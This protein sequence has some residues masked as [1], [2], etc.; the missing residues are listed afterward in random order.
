MAVYPGVQGT[1]SRGPSY[2]ARVIRVLGTVE[3]KMKYA[4][5]LGGYLWSLTKPLAYFAVLLLVFRHLLTSSQT[6]NYEI[7]LLV[8]IVVFTFFVDAVSEMLPSIVSRGS[9]LRRMSFSPLLI[10]LSMSISVCLTFLVNIVA[11]AIFMAAFGIDPHP[12]WF[13]VLPLLLELYLFIVALGLVLAMLY[14]RFRDIGQIWELVSQILFFACGL[15][16]PIGILP[17]WVQK[18]VFLNPVVQALQDIRHALIGST[19]PDDVTAAQVYA[20]SGGRLI[21]ILVAVIV[22]LGAVAIFQREGRTFA[23]RI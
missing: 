17:E 12:S 4:D 14:V 22:F 7:F 21:P 23:E 11:V 9:M 5:S 3:F 15:M 10:P 1:T 13:L 16:Y 19:G 8:G 2:Y 6:H 18:I 20:G